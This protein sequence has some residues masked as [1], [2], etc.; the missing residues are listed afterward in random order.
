MMDR[1]DQYPANW[2]GVCNIEQIARRKC[3]DYLTVIGFKLSTLAQLCEG[4]PAKEGCEPEFWLN[5]NQVRVHVG[6]NIID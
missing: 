2:D 4:C 5:K 1:L 6:K 3:G